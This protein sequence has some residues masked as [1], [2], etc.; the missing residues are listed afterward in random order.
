MFEGKTD[1]I[2]WDLDVTNF[3][4]RNNILLPLLSFND[5]ECS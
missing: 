1:S 4:G 5:R 2:V 3:N